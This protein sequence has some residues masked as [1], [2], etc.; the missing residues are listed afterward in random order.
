MELNTVVL[1]GRAGSDLVI[2]TDEKRAQTFARFRM[3]VPRAR[4]KDNGEWEELEGKWYTVKAW[5]ILAKNL[6]MSIRKGHPLLVVGRPSSQAWINSDGELMSEIAINAIGIGHDLS[7]GVSEYA[8]VNRTSV[9]DQQIETV[10]GDTRMS[11]ESATVSPTKKEE[12]ELAD[13]DSVQDEVDA[14]IPFQGE[15]PF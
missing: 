3:V 1:R 11:T 8:K 12:P 2:H 10:I 5:G 4:R 6:N 15:A 13:Q 7:F 14:D 9:Q